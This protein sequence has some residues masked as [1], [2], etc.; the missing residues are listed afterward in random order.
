[1]IFAS[2]SPFSIPF[3]FRI[4]N[5]FVVIGTATVLFSEG[6]NIFCF[7]IFIRFLVF[8]VG[9]YFVALVRLLYPPPTVPVFCVMGHFFAICCV[10]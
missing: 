5:P 10:Y 8:P 6:I 3:F 7:C 2:R 1:M 4:L 9:L